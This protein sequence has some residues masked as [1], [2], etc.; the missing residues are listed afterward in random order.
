MQTRAFVWCLQASSFAR[1]VLWLHHLQAGTETRPNSA[2][3]LISQFVHFSKSPYS[4][5]KPS[6]LIR[7]FKKYFVSSVNMDPGLRLVPCQTPLLLC[8]VNWTGW[9][10]KWIFGAVA[11]L[12]LLSMVPW[13]PHQQCSWTSRFASLKS[14]LKKCRT[15]FLLTSLDI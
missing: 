8:E 5:S 12:T 14:G 2:P 11:R 1:E 13:W 10:R 3:I 15:A 4:P 7:T 9:A 6:V